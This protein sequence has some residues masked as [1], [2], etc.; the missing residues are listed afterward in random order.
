M[1]IT[2]SKLRDTVSAIQLSEYRE[3]RLCLLITVNGSDDVFISTNP[4]DVTGTP[5]SGI[6]IGAGENF[7]LTHVVHGEIIWYPWYASCSTSYITV[8]EWFCTPNIP[9]AVVTPSKTLCEATNINT[10][11]ACCK[12]K[13]KCTKIQAVQKKK[14]QELL[15]GISNGTVP[16]NPLNASATNGTGA[17]KISAS[18]VKELIFKQKRFGP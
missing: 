10:N 6:L 13:K 11:G 8:W 1:A 16:T 12:P 15:D 14:L 5:K 18:S 2:Y 3:T 9:G 17:K 4:V 7:V